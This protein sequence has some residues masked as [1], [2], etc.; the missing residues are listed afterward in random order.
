[1]LPA[2]APAFMNRFHCSPGPLVAAL[3]AE[4]REGRRGRGRP[5]AAKRT[6]VER[7]PG[8]PAE[9]R[10][11]TWLARFAL[12]DGRFAR[13]SADVC[14]GDRARRFH[15]RRAARHGRVESRAGSTASSA[16]RRDGLAASAHARFDRSRRRAG[17]RRRCRSARCISSPANRARR[18]SRTSLAA[19][20]RRALQEA[21]VPNWAS[22]FVA[23]T[24][25]GTEL[26]VGARAP[27]GFATSS[28]TLPISAGGTRRCHFLDSCLPL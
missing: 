4:R 6:D 9:D 23:I 16:R 8:G 12:A 10:E 24:D 2:G 18:S 13:A 15:R 26:D 21:R 1:M 14:R 7:R 22:H 27:K 11:S 19:H 3:E 5:L 20:F 25:P 28:P 17:S